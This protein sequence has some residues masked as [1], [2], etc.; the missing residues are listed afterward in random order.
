MAIELI[1]VQDWNKHDPLDNLITQY[2]S[3][4]N[5]KLTT[6]QHRRTCTLY[7]KSNACRSAFNTTSKYVYPCTLHHYQT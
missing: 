5:V 7:T 3:P 2:T 4:A 1:M 6:A